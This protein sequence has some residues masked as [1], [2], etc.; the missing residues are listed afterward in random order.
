MTAAADPAAPPTAAPPLP[1]VT[2]LTIGSL[3]LVVIGGIVMAG[4]FPNAP[5]LVLPVVLLVG[6]ALLWAASLVLLSRHRGFAWPVLFRVGR[7]ALLAYAVIA[8]MIEYAFIH[9]QASG[10]PL[11]V[12][13]LMLVMF[14]LVVPLS[15]GFTVARFQD[16]PAAHSG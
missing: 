9:N 16:P 7:W 6:S 3:A 10:A 11:L 12:L 14:A 15:I 4:N 8:G 1:P 5:S 13:T 2:Q